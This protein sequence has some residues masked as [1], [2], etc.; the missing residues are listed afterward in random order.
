MRRTTWLVWEIVLAAGVCQTLT[1][2]EPTLHKGS[3]I[4]LTAPGFSRKPIIGVVDSV[5]QG[6]VT[7]RPDG[8]PS[9]SI[10]RIPLSAL[11]QL[12]ISRRQTR[13]TW[14]K[15]APLWLTAAAGVT[16]ALIGYGDNDPVFGPDGSALILG[17]LCGALGLFVGTGIAIGVKH[18]TWEPVAIPTQSFR[19]S[20]SPSL[21]LRPDSKA[22]RLGMR[23]AF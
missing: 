23:A 2:Q 4:R 22:L 15:T 21:Y 19:S 20:I 3:R 5:S 6:T 18:D 8:A 14:S 12:E 11:S 13:P 16:G 9:Y 1:A 10:T 17:G 7:M